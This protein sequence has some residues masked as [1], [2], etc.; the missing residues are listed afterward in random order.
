MG[1][2]VLFCVNSA[3]SRTNTEADDHARMEDSEGGN[4]RECQ[5]YGLLR[6]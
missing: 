1:K 5:D 3:A 2:I 4:M 6:D